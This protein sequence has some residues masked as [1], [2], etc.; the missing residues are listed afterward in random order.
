[1][2]RVTIE[3]GA[4]ARLFSADYADALKIYINDECVYESDGIPCDK[5]P[6]RYET[7]AMKK[8]LTEHIST[9]HITSENI[10]AVR[11]D[12]LMPFACDWNGWV[13]DLTAERENK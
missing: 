1:M 2:K 9:L 3:S 5:L 4:D 6:P 11:A 7:P 13:R 10:G 8:M 12:L